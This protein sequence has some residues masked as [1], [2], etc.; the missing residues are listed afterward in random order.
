MDQSH[1][2]Q[3]H[4]KHKFSISL[5]LGDPFALSTISVAIIGWIIAFA[6]S[7]SS[8][9]TGTYPQFSWWGLAYQFALII[10]I[11]YVLASD[12]VDLYRLAVVG[13]A[14]AGLVYSTN[15][16]NNL[17]YTGR[18]ADAAAAAGNILLSIV[19]CLW[20]FYFG[21]SSDAPPH[22]F[23]D[24]Y[25]LGKDSSVGTRSHRS[26]T[27]SA[28]GGYAAGAHT[29]SGHAHTGSGSV[30]A[31][32]RSQTAGPTGTAPGIDP[33]RYA[34]GMAPSTASAV[35]TPTYPHFPQQQQQLQQQQQQQQHMFTSA[36][37]SGFETASI[38]GPTGTG[39]ATS[40]SAPVSATLL[41]P[42]G[43]DANPVPA[44]VVEPLDAPTD[45]PLR[46]R[47]I[48]SYNAN[49][50]DANEI[51]FSKGEILEIADVSGRW[52][53]ARKANGEVGIC[54]SNYVQ[55]LD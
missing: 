34:R 27:S 54:P 10:G 51:S 5:L 8:D 28:Q 23:I 4:K 25:A 15:S 2:Q 45:Y 30:V 48:Y 24:S 41:R 1:Y 39:T 40:S 29:G 43:I 37:L 44:A 9:T 17:V 33:Y 38:G 26:V 14:S 16:T 47:A 22:A 32:S 53:Q 7:V 35:P 50:D 52:W 21:T 13:F 36:Q 55:L 18:A 11:T 3:A 12:A 6:A 31:T 49:P 20:I 19:N 42:S 46:A